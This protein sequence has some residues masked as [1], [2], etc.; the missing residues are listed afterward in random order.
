MNSKNYT[1]RFFLLDWL[2]FWMYCVSA[3]YF[4]PLLQKFGFS[5]LRIGITLTIS[6]ALCFAIQL[7]SGYICD[8]TN[9][10]REIVAISSL[11]SLFALIISLH[12]KNDILLYILP[13]LIH[14]PMV[15]TQFIVD[16]WMSK[17]A[18]EGYNL[19]YGISRSGG[20]MSAAIGA[21]VYGLAINRFGFSIAPWV[22]LGLLIL[23]YAFG[24]SLPQPSFSQNHDKIKAKD[25]MR[26]L[27]QNKAYIVIVVAYF[28]V[29]LSANTLSFYAVL[30]QSV[31]GTTAHYGL[32]VFLSGIFE[33]PVMFFF[34]K[35]HK[36]IG[37][38][39]VLFAGI[40]GTMFRCLMFSF[41]TD[42]PTA[43]IFSISQMFAFAL[44]F[45]AMNTYIREIVDH[46][47][48]STAFL[49]ITAM[50]TG[51]GSIIGSTMW[52]AIA[53]VYGIQAMYRIGIIPGFVAI[54]ILLIFRPVIKR[55]QS[56]VYPA[57]Q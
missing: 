46:K 9:R 18:G 52:G 3:S 49:A 13:T 32:G 29:F 5:D 4:V 55:G 20:A 53:Q 48:L 19:N 6:S 50:S 31:G 1:V 33:T 12:I 15:S 39:G 21:L 17:L 16:S 40:I 54:V 47:Y 26:H 38:I 14:A 10:P 27:L 41:A 36:K 23:F 56:I 2:F 8:K 43:L 22:L 45:P 37:S 57:A 24:L 7:L 30:V 11:I 34:A 35:F 44:F 25:A 28:F 51:I 42:V